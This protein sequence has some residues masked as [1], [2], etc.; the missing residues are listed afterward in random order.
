M[1]DPINVRI[2]V[3]LI[4]AGG[5]I[6]TYEI[7]SG[8]LDTAGLTD[9]LQVMRQVPNILRDLADQLDHGFDTGELSG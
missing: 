8:Q 9:A 3:E 6:T 7:G 4:V 5:K 1:T 2:L